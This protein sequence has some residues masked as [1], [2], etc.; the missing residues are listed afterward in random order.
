MV[1]YNLRKY[2]FLGERGNELL[3]RDNS[4]ISTVKKCTHKRKNSQFKVQRLLLYALLD[5]VQQCRRGSKVDRP[6]PCQ[7]SLEDPPELQ[8]FLDCRV[9]CD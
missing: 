2:Y 5:L 8:V 1:I 4:G 3:K 7:Y 6:Y 9:L